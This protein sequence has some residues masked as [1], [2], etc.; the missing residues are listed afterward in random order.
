MDILNIAFL[1][2]I[3]GSGIGIMAVLI[4]IAYILIKSCK[5]SDNK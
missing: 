2:F 1:I 5:E 3:V 4:A